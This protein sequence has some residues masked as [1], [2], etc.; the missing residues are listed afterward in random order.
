MKKLEKFMLD[1]SS[2]CVQK[3]FQRPQNKKIIP[4]DSCNF[5]NYREATEFEKQGK[6]YVMWQFK[7]IVFPEISLHRGMTPHFACLSWLIYCM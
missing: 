7:I 4:M 2:S 3:Y 6:K 5:N 1:I